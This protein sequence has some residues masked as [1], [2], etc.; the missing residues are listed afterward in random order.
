MRS[1]RIAVPLLAVFLLSL[2]CAA[3]VEQTAA[4]NVDRSPL[5]T[6]VFAGNSIVLQFDPK[7]ALGTTQPVTHAAD[8]IWFS[9]T[10]LTDGT[11]ANASIFLAGTMY[12]GAPTEPPTAKPYTL[13]SEF[14]YAHCATNGLEATLVAR[15]FS[16]TYA[17]KTTT[18][19][20]SQT[21]DA[22]EP[23]AIAEF[24]ISA[25]LHLKGTVGDGTVTL[26]YDY[27]GPNSGGSVHAKAVLL[28]RT[29]KRKPS[30]H[31]WI[32]W[33]GTGSCEISLIGQ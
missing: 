28:R 15:V 23:C 25:E 33:D 22:M 7:T 1:A 24:P 14:Q 29:D 21:I 12:V 9:L 13:A 31:C 30:E 4:Q 10:P 18:F 27:I 5:Q 17:A 26:W 2:N 19:E 8:L 16:V 6:F 11:S 32:K 3:P 20:G